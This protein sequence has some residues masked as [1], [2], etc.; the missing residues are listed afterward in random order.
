V[1]WVHFAKGGRAWDLGIVRYET[2]LF[3]LPH[4]LRH[5]LSRSKEY[6]LSFEEICM[7][8]WQGLAP[9][10]NLSID[11]DC[12][13]SILQDRAGISDRVIDFLDRLGTDIPENTY[14]AYSPEYSH[15]TLEAF[16]EL[17]LVLE[18]RFGQRIEW[19]SP[20]LKSGKFHLAGTNARLSRRPVRKLIVAM[21][22]IGIY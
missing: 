20:D 22:R 16:K 4:R 17:L 18:G 21:R 13:A 9:G 7:E 3:S 19:L 10:D 5:V 11:W 2:D 15:P 6:P 12:F 14:V 1:R 8:E